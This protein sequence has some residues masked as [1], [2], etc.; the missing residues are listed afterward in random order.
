[1]NSECVVNL[2]AR[3]FQDYVTLCLNV[4]VKNHSLKEICYC[5]Y[6]LDM[7]GCSHYLSPH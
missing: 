2:V 1:M 4:P 3:G 5:T 6:A 7:Y